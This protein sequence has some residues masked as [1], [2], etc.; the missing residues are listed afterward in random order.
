MKK[1]YLV[2][3]FLNSF[4]FFNNSYS[5]S[6]TSNYFSKKITV[7]AGKEYDRGGFYELFFG[8]HWRK[9]WTTPFE[10][11]VLDLD[12]TAGGLT[13]YKRGGGL[14]TK[15]LRF[16]GSDGKTY[17]FRSINKDPRRILPPDLQSSIFADEVQ[18]QISTSHPMSAIIVAPLLNQV[19]ILNAEP[20]V[21]VL[22]KDNKLGEYETEFSGMLGTFEESPD[23]GTDGEKGFAESDKVVN[24]FKLYKK[25]EKDNS[26][27]VDNT[28]FLKARL[29]D[30]MIGDWDRHSD[31]WLWAGYN[32][33][34][35][36][37]YEPIPR[38]RDQAFSLYDGLFPYI[39]GQSVTQIEG[40]GNNY[41]LIY[42][43]SFNGRYLDRRF[44]PP[45]PKRVYDSLTAYIQSRITNDVITKAV[46]KI[47]DQWFNLEGN[48]L[49]GMIQSRRDKLK[50]ASDEFYDL[51]NETADVYG[52]DKDEY[53]DIRK[54]N[55][56]VEV[57]LFE[58]N[59][60][61]DHNAKPFFDRV[62]KSDQT[63]EIRIY[64][65]GGD[66]KITVNPYLTTG[67]EPDPGIT[68]K[69]LEGKGKKEIDDRSGVLEV[70]KDERPKKDLIEKN[71]PKIE[72]RSTDFRI[73]PVI[74][75]N[76]DDG[77]ILGGGP[78]LYKFGLYVKPYVYRMS[79]LGS[80]AFGAKSYSIKY[81]GDSYSIIKGA[82]IF[83]D[84]QKTELGITR[85]FGLGN[86]TGLN[87]DL[88]NN[89]YYKV[90]QE[91]IYISPNFE[92]P[93]QKK[94]KFSFSPFYKYSDV[95]YN[96]NTFLGQIPSTYGIGGIKF[97]GI[98]SSLKYDSR[99]NEQEPYKGI[100]AQVLGGYTPNIFKNNFGFS[101]AGFDI[102][103]YAS[104]D[105]VRGITFAIRTAGGK[106]WG[107]FPFYESMFLGGENSLK[108]YSRERFA[109]DGVL[110]A[111]SEV[112]FRLFR[113]N[114]ILPG[115]LGVSF[116]GG[117]GR[118]FLNSETSKKWHNSYGGSLWMTYLNRL[119]NLGFTVAKSDE[120]FKFFVGT[121]LFL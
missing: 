22:P 35:K 44:L 112:R 76:S 55:D 40:Y 71:E 28:E 120:G 102:R 56:S 85:F 96:Q 5:Q 106:V 117:A 75:Y 78:I 66:D 63:N 27:Q 38:D 20:I 8:K 91:L 41:P 43:L 109:G 87:K 7:V 19:G 52:S 39:A 84:V 26:N 99:D 65:N 36:T 73:G 2:V 94:I 111:Q 54:F 92:F 18:D 108:G 110:L 13:P 4:F 86:E 61:I 72:D 113:T 98:K 60:D 100:F 119:F 21:V 17:K 121:A 30:L 103:A 88:D 59:K 51:I 74:S 1:I 25:L 80:Y 10:A 14:Q 97:A 89:G 79:L 50:D 45:V 58:K 11:G 57:L 116:F 42:N 69:V 104:T 82:R 33:D 53:V 24:S 118:V 62:F 46:K 29:V 15:S 16:K 114:I 6:D 83:L 34:G 107:T 70:I 64:T 48:H 9:L 49:I 37:F 77:F 93:V 12:K 105:T 23:N 68:I 101:K 31:Q 67:D 81:T 47:P 3:L 95:S 90:G 115:T 32:K